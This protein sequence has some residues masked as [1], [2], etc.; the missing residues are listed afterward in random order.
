MYKELIHEVVVVA[1]IYLTY[2]LDKARQDLQILWNIRINKPIVVFARTPQQELLIVQAVQKLG[3]IVAVTGDGC[4]CV[5]VCRCVCG[6]V[7]VSTI[8]I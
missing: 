6:Y 7:R 4:D 1:G 3:C 5:C 8:V 2:M